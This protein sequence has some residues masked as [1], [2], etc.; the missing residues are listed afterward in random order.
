MKA[1]YR[2]NKKIKCDE[3]DGVGI[4]ICPY[5]KSNFKHVKNYYSYNCKFCDCL[6]IYLCPKCKGKKYI[7]SKNC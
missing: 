7:K 6:Y 5:C 4:I 2:K 3:C 1:Y